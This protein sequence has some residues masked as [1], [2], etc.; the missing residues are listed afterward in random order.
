MK[1]NSE[2]KLA[3]TCT[4]LDNTI[5]LY[6]FLSIIEHKLFICFLIIFKGR[7]LSKSKN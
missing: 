1:G 7:I 4:G 6:D 3:R 2:I 5:F